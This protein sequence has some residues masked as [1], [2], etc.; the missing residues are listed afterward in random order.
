MAW[1]T[2]LART[3]PDEAEAGGGL[4]VAIVRLAITLG[5]TLGGVVFDMAGARVEFLASAG[6]SSLARWPPSRWPGG[7]EPDQYCPA[8]WAGPEQ[9]RGLRPDL[10]PLVRTPELR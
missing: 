5:A 10:P 9:T 4:M 8:F 6:C 2:W 7:L 3:V 1:W